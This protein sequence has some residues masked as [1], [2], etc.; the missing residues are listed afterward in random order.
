[1]LAIGDAAPP[2]CPGKWLQGEPLAAF[3]PG[4]VYVVEFWATWCG[5][6]K[7]SIP[8]LNELHLKYKD[9]GLVVIGQNCWER[10]DAAVEPFVKGM[11]D[12]MTYRVTA[13][14]KSDGGRGK[15]AN[16]WMSAAGRNG[17]PAAF[18]VDQQGK[19]AWIGHP[20]KMDT[21]LLDEILAGKYDLKKAAE[22]A[23]QVA[24]KAATQAATSPAGQLRGLQLTLTR[25]LAASQWTEAEATMAQIDKLATGLQPPTMKLVYNQLRLKLFLAKNDLEGAVTFASALVEA[26]PREDIVP[27][28]ITS[29]LA[30]CPDL[31]GPALDFATKLA[32]EGNAKGGPNA[33]SYVVPLARLEMIQGHQD[34]AVE[35]QT[36]AIRDISK[37]AADTTR[38]HLLADLESY[39]AGKLPPAPVPPAPAA[40]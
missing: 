34:K 19:I 8:H 27:I 20:M 13:D 22:A 11:A 5:P 2:L 25:Q 29:D 37:Q 31:K 30:N 26:N 18:I 1:V 24:G 28:L 16:A 7:A 9:K 39:K 6:C 40:K 14:D 32:R 38:V 33:G 23:A 12:K 36:Q 10:N 15:M 35:L 21:V 4:T 17:I 3:A